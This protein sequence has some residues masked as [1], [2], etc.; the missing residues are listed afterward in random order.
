MNIEQ[1][2]PY[3]NTTNDAIKMKRGK[4]NFCK[5]K[6]KTHKEKKKEEKL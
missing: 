2:F 5:I 6:E 1:T 3:L 4:R